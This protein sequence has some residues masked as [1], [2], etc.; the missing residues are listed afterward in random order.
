MATPLSNVP[1][2]TIKNGNN[3]QHPVGP[4]C[5]NKWRK[6]C[7][8]VD[9]ITLGTSNTQLPWMSLYKT[10][11]DL[12]KID[13]VTTVG[14][15]L[16]NNNIGPAQFMRGFPLMLQGPDS[17]FN[18]SGNILPDHWEYNWPFYKNNVEKFTENLTANNVP[19]WLNNANGNSQVITDFKNDTRRNLLILDLSEYY[20]HNNTDQHIIGHED[21]DEINNRK[22]PNYLV[23]RLDTAIEESCFHKDCILGKARDDL[24]VFNYV[25]SGYVISPYDFMANFTT[26]YLRSVKDNKQYY[27][28]RDKPNISQTPKEDIKDTIQLMNN[29]GKWEDAFVPLPGQSKSISRG[30]DKIISPFR[31]NFHLFPSQ[32]EVFDFLNENDQS[33]LNADVSDNPIGP[34]TDVYDIS[35][36]FNQSRFNTIESTLSIELGPHKPVN[37]EWNYHI[38]NLIWCSLSSSRH[39]LYAKSNI[40]RQLYIGNYLNI[41]EVE[42]NE[43]GTYLSENEITTDTSGNIIS[44]HE[45]SNYMPTFKKASGSIIRGF[46]EYDT[47]VGLNEVNMPRKTLTPYYKVDQ[48]TGSDYNYENY[49]FNWNDTSKSWSTLNST[50]IDQSTNKINVSNCTVVEYRNLVEFKDNMS[51]QYTFNENKKT[52]F[53]T[54][55]D[56]IN[57]QWKGG[58]VLDNNSIKACNVNGV[59]LIDS[60]LRLLSNGKNK[61]YFKVEWSG[62]D[63]SANTPKYGYLIDVASGSHVLE[64]DDI[65]YNRTKIGTVEDTFLKGTL[66]KDKFKIISRVFQIRLDKLKEDKTLDIEG[67]KTINYNIDSNGTDVAIYSYP[68]NYNETCP[69]FGYLNFIGIRSTELLGNAQNYLTIRNV[70]RQLPP[71]KPTDFRIET[72]QPYFI[73]DNDANSLKGFKN[74]YK[75]SSKIIYNSNIFYSRTNFSSSSVMLSTADTDPLDVDYNSIDEFLFKNKSPNINWRSPYSNGLEITSISNNKINTVNNDKGIKL[76]LFSTNIKLYITSL[77]G[78]SSTNERTLD[79]AKNII[80]KSIELNNN[81]KMEYIDSGSIYQKNIKFNFLQY[82]NINFCCSQGDLF[83]SDFWKWSQPLVS[84]EEPELRYDG[85]P[86]TLLN[87]NLNKRYNVYNW[88]DTDDITV[89]D[90]IYNNG[91]H[92]PQFAFENQSLINFIVELSSISINY[93]H[94]LVNTWSGAKIGNKFQSIGLRSFSDSAGNFITDSNPVFKITILGGDQITPKIEETPAIFDINVNAKFNFATSEILDDE[95]GNSKAPSKIS[96]VNGELI[97]FTNA[98]FTESQEKK[99]WFAETGFNSSRNGIFRNEDGDIN[100]YNTIDFSSNIISQSPTNLLL[101]NSSGNPISGRFS[102]KEQEFPLELLFCY[103]YDISELSVIPKPEGYTTIYYNSDGV[104]AVVK[105]ADDF[106]GHKRFSNIYAISLTGSSSYGNENFENRLVFPENIII[107][108]VELP[109]PLQVNNSNDMLDFDNNSVKIVWKGYNFTEPTNDFRSTYGDTGDIIWKIERFQTQLGIKKTIFEGKLIPDQDNYSLSTY[110]YIDNSVRIYDKYIYTVSGKY[111]YKFKRVFTNTNSNTLSLNFGSFNTD[112]ILICKNNK[113]QYGRYNTTSTNLK[114]FRPLLIKR[115]GGQVD[116]QGKQT[117]GGLC[118]GN[119][120]SGSTRIS[121][122]QNIYANTTNTLTKKQTY[123]LLSKQQYKPFR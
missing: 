67:N 15:E 89:D 49:A 7:K 8:N 122:S 65:S 111:E 4:N 20:L 70:F 14:Y 72:R 85:P 103:P 76:I 66:D 77:I 57:D 37:I 48:N 35:T 109:P 21:Y 56:P 112:E 82:N 86:N 29:K 107:N 91:V 114:L 43:A 115:D 32:L 40:S 45:N 42:Y 18:D 106:K 75:S 58:I 93:S 26:D 80:N 1:K 50:G 24:M 27:I 100:P 99:G 105:F 59:Q 116:E 5:Y 9:K 108:C 22:R 19:N 123:V 54:S 63:L 33:I 87:R 79:S 51:I 120:F 78:K 23:I 101:T 113:F 60:N 36:T 104:K 53:V 3:T 6:M 2:F 25:Y 121:S 71:N 118:I 41:N 30:Q 64:G 44:A 34:A 73:I 94:V 84:C 98:P 83:L 10:H 62:T 13:L 119:I 88:D 74:A 68:I 39:T 31:Y 55:V 117:A 96:E 110:T 12:L 46:T 28:N 52:T 97:N 47:M 69:L 90:T 102:I 81:L 17:Q 92:N 95:A 61:E 16:N 38:E 11:K